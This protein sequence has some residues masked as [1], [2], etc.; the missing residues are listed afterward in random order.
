MQ[1]YKRKRKNE[2]FYDPPAPVHVWL[3]SMVVVVACIGLVVL[4]VFAGLWLT[5]DDPHPAETLRAVEGTQTALAQT[6]QAPLGTLDLVDTLPSPV[7][8]ITP[9]PTNAALASPILRTLTPLPTPPQ[10]PTLDD[11]YT[12]RTDFVQ[13]PGVA[14]VGDTLAAAGSRGVWLYDD[15]AL[16][17]NPTLLEV[18]TS[19][20]FA[21]AISPAGHWLAAGAGDGLVRVWSLPDGQKAHELEGHQFP[22]WAVAFSASGDLLLS[23]GDDGK[24]YLWE[25][26]SGTPLTVFSIG[27][28]GIYSVAFDPTGRTIAAASYDGTIQLWDATTYQLLYTLTGHADQVW[29]LVYNPL[30]TTL[31]SAGADGTIRLWNVQTGEA[32]TVLDDGAVPV[33]ELAFSPDGSR[34][35]AGSEDGF[36]RIWDMASRQV[37]VSV[38]HRFAVTSLCFSPDGAFLATGG[39]DGAL[40]LWDTTSG[41]LYRSYPGR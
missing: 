16:G 11:T 19:E 18:P 20:V 1:G 31:A 8:S 28:G 27:G 12:P 14:W 22:V 30:G 9:S 7:V 34:L 2:E 24:I 41:E 37:I 26:G 10:F 3:W 5:Q 23:G 33:R 17:A 15:D 6:M 32:I 40:K 38:A 39:E 36:A 21:I 29:T 25:V 4:T 13:I 35:A